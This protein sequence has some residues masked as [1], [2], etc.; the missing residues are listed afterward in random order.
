MQRK[1]VLLSETYSKPGFA[2]QDPQCRY[3]F[4]ISKI[5]YMQQFLEN[6]GNMH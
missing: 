1:L 2:L 5:L 6:G 4:D 3:I